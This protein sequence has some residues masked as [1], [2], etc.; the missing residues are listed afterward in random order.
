MILTFLIL[1][2]WYID[3]KRDSNK[4][5]KKEKHVNRE[6][7]LCNHLYNIDIQK[8]EHGQRQRFRRK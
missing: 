8:E 6:Y 5:G 4:L 2:M 7:N 1:H 3:Q